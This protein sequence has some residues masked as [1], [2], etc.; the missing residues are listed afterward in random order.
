MLDDRYMNGGWVQV[1]C[2][3]VERRL[4][5]GR[6]DGWMDGCRLDGRWMEGRW[7]PRRLRNDG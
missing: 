3:E 2:M 5:G 6:V 4:S 1:G 7:K